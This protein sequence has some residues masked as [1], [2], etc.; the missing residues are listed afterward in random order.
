MTDMEQDVYDRAYTHYKKKKSMGYHG[1]DDDR[2]PVIEQ[3]WT[4][5]FL[6]YPIYTEGILSNEQRTVLGLYGT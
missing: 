6:G 2:P 5:Y 3:F 4:D 1:L